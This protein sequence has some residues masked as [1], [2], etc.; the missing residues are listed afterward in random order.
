MA[1]FLSDIQTQ[2]NKHKSEIEV[3]IHTEGTQIQRGLENIV[4]EKHLALHSLVGQQ[5]ADM[6]GKLAAQRRYSFIGFALMGMNIILL[7]ATIYWLLS[8]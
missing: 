8:H 6:S 4:T 7:V 1:S 5:F 3:A 2:L